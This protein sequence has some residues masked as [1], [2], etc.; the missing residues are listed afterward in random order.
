MSDR[1]R[2]SSSDAD[3]AAADGVAAA[4]AAGSGPRRVALEIAVT[5]LAGARTALAEGADRVELCTALEIGGVTPSQG[6]TEAVVATGV[7]VHALVRA[8]GGDF[9]Y[10]DADLAVMEH[11]VRTL[12]AAGVAGVVVGALRADGSLDVDAVARLVS[13][14]RDAAGVRPAELG[15]SRLDVTVHRAVD[16]AASPVDAVAALSALGVDRVLTSGGASRARDGLA[17]GALPDIVAAAGGVEVMAGGG[18]RLDDVA[19]LVAAGVAAVHLSASTAATSARGEGNGPSPVSLG[20]AGATDAYA[21]TDA[22]LVRAVRA[23]L[24]AAEL[25]RTPSPRTP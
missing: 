14:A 3:I 24:D 16:R 17:S 5:S 25:T 1:T 11:E 23:A 9:V 12:V 22:S 2:T 13:A 20:S 19:A 15:G 6:L 4:G 10:D 7:P 18:V 21:V 8:R